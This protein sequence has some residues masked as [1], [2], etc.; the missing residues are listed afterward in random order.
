[1]TKTAQTPEIFSSS[2]TLEP[3]PLFV[4]A[5]VGWTKMP[6]K[7]GLGMVALQD[8]KEGAV[9]ENCPVIIMPVAE[10]QRPDGS[11]ENELGMYAFHWGPEED[12]TSVECAVVKGGMLPLANHSENPNSDV[13]QNHPEK[14]IRWF[15]LRDIQKGEEVTINYATDLWFDNQEE[16]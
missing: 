12:E 5:P 2:K 9:I 15:A 8:I 3:D 13:K 6:G 11:G 4:R 1:M 14:L 7:G 16:T 10:L